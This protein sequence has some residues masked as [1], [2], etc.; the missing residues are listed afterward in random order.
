METIESDAPSSP[1]RAAPVLIACADAEAARRL[2]AALDGEYRVTLVSEGRAAL[3]AMGRAPFELCIITSL[4][5]A[6]GGGLDLLRALRARPG[7]ARLPVLLVSDADEEAWRIAGLEAGADDHMTAPFDD[8]ELRV[9]VA[10]LLDSSRRGPGEGVPAS[11]RERAASLDSRWFRAFFEGSIDGIV[12]IDAA[13]RIL[14][15]SPGV[16]TLTGLPASEAVGRQV[17]DVQHRLLPEEKRTPEGLRLLREKVERG[18]SE[19]T[20]FSRSLEDEIQ[21]EDGTRRIIQSKLFAVTGGGPTAAGGVIR[22]VTEQKRLERDLQERQALLAEAESLA[23]V[24][25]WSI[26]LRSGECFWSDEMYRILG[27]ARGTVT[28]CSEAFHDA[29]MEEDRQRVLDTTRATEDDGRL[30]R[31]DCRLRTAEGELRHLHFLVRRTD[32]D[33]GRPSRLIGTVQ[34]V[35]EQKQ[36]LEQ[37]R[38]SEQRLSLALDAS[39]QGV[40]DWDIVADTA[41]VSPEY[42]RLSGY[43]A[44]EVRSAYAF[45]QS[46]VHPDDLPRVETVMREHLEG[47]RPRSFVEYRL[48]KQSGEYF[49]VAGLGCVTNRNPRGAPLRMTGVIADIHEEKLMGTSCERVRLC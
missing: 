13:G 45:F 3:Q 44:G 42:S 39:A 24:G 2:E 17:W 12:L 43:P 29:I 11:P 8:R 49:W 10:R 18:L 34:D 35:S 4:A 47:R 15:W 9:R 26:D 25:H 27:V 22:D 23:R 40:W 31:V 32:E 37:L 6:P 46:T 7:T 5:D 36:A 19:A 16:E 14:E 30:R 48:K 21:R 38:R 1:V 20:G 28:E 33:D 41:Y